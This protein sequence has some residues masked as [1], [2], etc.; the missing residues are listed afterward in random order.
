MGYSRVGQDGLFYR[1][2]TKVHRFL[3][4]PLTL[5]F[6]TLNASGDSHQPTIN[7]KNKV[8]VIV[9][10]KKKAMDKTDYLVKYLD[11]D[12]KNDRTRAHFKSEIKS[13]NKEARSNLCSAIVKAEQEKEGFVDFLAKSFS[14]IFAETV[15]YVSVI[16]FTELAMTLLS[17]KND[18]D[19]LDIFF[20]T[21]HELLE[22]VTPV[23]FENTLVFECMGKE[24][25]EERKN[26]RSKPE[27]E[28][29]SELIADEKERRERRMEKYPSLFLFERLSTLS[30]EQ[31]NE[32]GKHF[33]GKKEDIKSIHAYLDK[34][35]KEESHHSGK[36]KKSSHDNL[37]KHSSSSSDSSDDENEEKKLLKKK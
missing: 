6:M 2:E 29:R 15:P 27:P 18:K 20:K 17:Q 31:L 36:E 1:K 14:S 11:L 3:M 25:L 21:T 9:N 33:N 5:A 10:G 7:E 23:Y 37:R 4:I 16:N 12:K 32:V 34:M 30:K 26:C 24:S 28:K 22:S 13:I 19:Y 35:I 8:E